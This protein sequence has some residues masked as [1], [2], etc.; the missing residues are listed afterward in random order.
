MDKGQHKFWTNIT[1][2]VKLCEAIAFNLET[3]F[4][5]ESFN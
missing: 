2:C 4:N 3:Q 5:Q 1:I